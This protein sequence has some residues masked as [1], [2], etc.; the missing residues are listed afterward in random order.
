RTFSGLLPHDVAAKFADSID[1]VYKPINS[2]N[3]I[4]FAQIFIAATNRLGQTVFAINLSGSRIEQ[5]LASTNLV[6]FAPVP[7]NQF[8]GPQTLTLQNPSYT[9]T[10]IIDSLSFIPDVGVF[11]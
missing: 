5:F 2:P 11:G 9:D 7:V 3:V 4:S 6:A 8:A 10:L 1:I